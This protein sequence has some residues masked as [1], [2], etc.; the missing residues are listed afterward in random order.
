MDSSKPSLKSALH[1]GLSWIVLCLMFA[2]HVFDEAIHGF[3]SVYNPIVASIRRQYPF[4]LFPIFNFREWLILLIAAVVI[5]LVFSL[6]AFW[7]ARW[8]KP[9]SYI[10]S[11]IMIL[12]G[13]LHISGSIVLGEKIPGVYSS[14]LLIA[15]GVY[16]FI[17]ARRAIN[18]N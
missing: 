16:L 4:L 3:L 13:L 18:R 6:F 2:I 15:A 10:F 1:W 8:M 11:V 12:N 9:L 17:A 14:P 7:E 5:L